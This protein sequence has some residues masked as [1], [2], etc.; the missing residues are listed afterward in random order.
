MWSCVCVCGALGGG[1]GG[2]A[3]DIIYSYKFMTVCEFAHTP[4]HFGVASSSSTLSRGLFLLFRMNGT[5]ILMS[6]RVNVM[7][8][9]PLTLDGGPGATDTVCV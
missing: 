4:T 5:M 7:A 1:N 3:L 2:R 9:S 6:A 8:V